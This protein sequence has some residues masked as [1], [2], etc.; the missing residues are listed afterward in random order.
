M[1]LQAIPCIGE[2]KYGNKPFDHSWV[3]VNGEI[4]DASIYLSLEGYI[5][6]PIY[7]SYNIGSL[8]K[9]IG[10]YGV[11][12]RL[13]ITARKVAETTIVDYMC[14][15]PE[16]HNGLWDY[17]YKIGINVGIDIDINALKSKYAN[18]MRTLR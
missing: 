12:Q 15:F 18:T 10:Q 7:K 11:E 17:V 6:D 2:V 3:E 8:S 4:Y 5:A 16:N 9:E 1:G 13:D 14:G